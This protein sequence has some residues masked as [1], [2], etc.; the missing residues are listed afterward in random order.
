MLRLRP[1]LQRS[2]LINMRSWSTWATLYYG[3]S[4]EV[5]LLRLP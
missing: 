2:I 4:A 1:L 3:H 5:P